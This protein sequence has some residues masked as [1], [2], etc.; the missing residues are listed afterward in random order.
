MADSTQTE[1]IFLS[2]SRT[3]NLAEAVALRAG[4]EQAGFT[5]FRDEDSIYA[6]DNWMQRLQAALQGCSAFVLLYGRDGVKRWVGAEVQYALSRHLSPHD[7]P[8]RLPIFPILLPDGDL[9]SLPPFLSL[10]QVQ[11]WQL[12]EALPERL[13]QAIRDK[14]EWQDGSNTFD[15]CP[16]LGLS[17]FQ[18]Q[19]ARL[20]FGRRKETLEAL[21]FLGAQREA[22]PENHIP[23]DGQYCRWLQIEG[24]SGAGKSS[25]VNAGM[26]PLIRQGALW[27]RTSYEKWRIIGPMMPGKQPLKQLAE[28]LEHAFKPDPA[29]RD[30]LALRRRMEADEEVLTSL[31]ADHKQADTALLLVVDQFEEL[32]TFAEEAEK[33]QFDAQLAYALADATC[34]LFLISTVRIDFLD[35]FEKLGKL[36][37][38]YNDQCKRYLLKTLSQDGIREVITQPARLAGLDASEI[39]PAILSDTENE[40][41]ALPLVEN[42][43][44]YLWEHRKDNRLSYELYRQ[45]GRLV[46]LLGMQADALLE[47]LDK[48]K[49]LPKGREGALELL[50]ALT[51]INP[52]GNHTRERIPLLQ[53]RQIAGDENEAKGQAIIDYLAGR[54]Q[55]G[56]NGGLRLITTVGDGRNPSPAL[57]LSGKGALPQRRTADGGTPGSS[58]DKGRLGGVSSVS[59]DLIHETLIRARPDEKTGKLVGYWQTL[60]RYIDNNRDRLFYRDQLKEQA[61]AWQGSGWFGRWWRL[62]GWSDLRHFRKVRPGRA[63][64][65]GCFL[66]WSERMAWVQGGVLALL[67]AFVGQAYLWTLDHGL[68]PNYMLTQQKFR[69][70]N[71]GWLTEPLPEMVEKAIQPPE[72]EFLVGEYDKEF[73]EMVNKALKDI[74][75]YG[76]QNFGYPAANATIPQPFFI[77]KYEVTYEQYDY[78]VWQQQGAENPPT[79]P[80]N[81]PNESGR[82][83]RAVVNV[84]WNDAN[85]YLQWLGKKS[86]ES[87]RLPTEAEWEYAARARTDTPY[88]WGDKEDA[89]GM[90]NCNGCG[91]Q[92]DNKFVAPVGSFKANDFGLHDTAG[93]VWEWTCS[94]WKADIDEG[95][96]HC[97]EP[98]SQS[99]ARVLRGGSWYSKPDWLRSSA[100]SWGS[101]GNRINDVGFRVLRSARTK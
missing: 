83:Q 44:H 86:G 43:L 10:F 77:G 7:D 25:L 71:L 30:S 1:Q 76:Q 16:Y 74:G 50:L 33:R 42:A 6:G 69:L 91:S 61:A 15:G 12:G 36:S 35:G 59:V 52:Q 79:Y 57:P 90:A 34:P 99:A 49:S 32:F 56:G 3:N 29:S 51:R 8:Q 93:N 67:L 31:L 84:S 21:K 78:Y 92:W 40:P 60:Y 96:G 54:R 70:M 47:R 39:T 63:T 41:G 23:M 75:S 14:S 11:R 73:G 24:N 94:E 62:A 64:Q 5:V 88:W 53:A 65:E 72:G 89:Q 9:G 22:N 27:A 38:R 97:V 100:R 46:G 13:A 66:R 98:K 85:A 87:Y 81:P 20:F 82:G 18:Q 101:T 19:D 68:P 48:D 58:P 2:Y 28:A 4:L 17:A 37:E 55:E 80:G 95:A 26:L 45:Q